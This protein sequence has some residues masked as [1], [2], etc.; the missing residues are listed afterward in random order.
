M[1]ADDDTLLHEPRALWTV[2]ALL[3]EALEANVEEDIVVS[4]GRVLVPKDDFKNTSRYP[5]TLTKMCVCAI[6]YTYREYEF[7]ATP[8]AVHNSM[9]AAQ[10]QVKIFL[11][12]PYSFHLDRNDFIVNQAPPDPTAEPGMRYDPTIGSYSSGIW[13]LNRWT[14]DRCLWLPRKAT[15]QL[16]IGTWI[17]PDLGFGAPPAIYTSVQFD[18]PQTG[19]LGGNNRLR[20]RAAIP[21]V[22]DTHAAAVGIP[23]PDAFGAGNG[24]T[25]FV[26]YPAEGL[27]KPNVFNRQESDR[28][29]DMNAFTGFAVALDQIDYDLA[30]QALGVDFAAKPIAPIGTRIVTR[31]K[32]S[33]GG[34]NE[35]WWRPNA[36][37]CLVSPTM[38][39]ATVYTLRKPIVLGP[40]EQLEVE[41]QAPPIVTI[42][43]TPFQPTYQIGVSFTGYA[44]IEG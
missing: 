33:N 34:T 19:I 38:G 30:I 14:F 43:D 24:G 6:G 10:N 26:T 25:S 5:I 16:D 35:W 32:C 23:A 17:I 20:A 1:R 37:L 41:L 39:P 2:Q 18:E 8:E 36:P 27:F 4:T 11:S 12:S 29:Q 9:M 21:A 13:G 42:D 31:A 15:L 3:A 28:G 44:T 22:F 7:T 40:G